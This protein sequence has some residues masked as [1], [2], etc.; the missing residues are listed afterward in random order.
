MS[1]QNLPIPDSDTPSCKQMIFKGMRVSTN[2]PRPTYLSVSGAFRESFW[3]IQ[4]VFVR[5]CRRSSGNSGILTLSLGMLSVIICCGAA[6]SFCVPAE[7][8]TAENALTVQQGQKQCLQQFL[9]KWHVGRSIS[10]K[11]SLTLPGR[12][13]SSERR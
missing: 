10:Q 2:H 7:S 11:T 9:G 12:S 4:E 3:S 6:L 1:P 8:P 13:L 5:R